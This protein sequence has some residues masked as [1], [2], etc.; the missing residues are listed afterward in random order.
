MLTISLHHKCFNGDFSRRLEVCRGDP[1]FQIWIQCDLSNYRAISVLPVV[2]KLLEKIVHDK[3]YRGLVAGDVLSEW[4]PGIRPGFSTA[5]AASY[6]F[7][8]ILTGMENKGGPQ[9]LTGAI[10]P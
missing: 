10:F 1:T 3:L 9:E 7:D 4:Q 6:F 2:S 8:E 5:T